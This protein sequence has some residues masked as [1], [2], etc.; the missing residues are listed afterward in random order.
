M[1]HREQTNA[2][3]FTILT[4]LAFLALFFFCLEKM[5]YVSDR[6]N[7]YTMLALGGNSTMPPKKRNRQKKVPVP[8]PKKVPARL[9]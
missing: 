5:A 8:A 4:L 9:E 3:Y 2:P 6:Q 7:D 1:L